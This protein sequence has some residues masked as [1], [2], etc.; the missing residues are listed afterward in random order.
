MTAEVK[1]YEKLPTKIEAV[2]LTTENREEIIDWANSNKG[3]IE[4]ARDGGVYIPT[5]EGTMLGK[6]TDYIIR[7]TEGEFYPC[8]ASVFESNYRE[9]V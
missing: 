9:V 7:G 1:T 4:A 2:Q 5:L 6:V 3:Y 8:K